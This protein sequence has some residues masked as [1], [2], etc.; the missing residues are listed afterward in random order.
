MS[1]LRLCLCVWRFASI[2]FGMFV[3][4]PAIAALIDD[5]FPKASS[6]CWGRVYDE[7]HLAKNAAQSVRAIY[8]STIDRGKNLERSAEDAA[9]VEDN[10]MPR[11]VV[12]QIY[13]ESR[14]GALIAGDTD[15]R[16]AA[17]GI[18]CFSP[19]SAT[20]G[21]E[22]TAFHLERVGERLQ[23]TAQAAAWPLRSFSELIARTD[24][25]STRPIPIGAEDRHFRLDRLPAAR[26][27][28]V[29]RR[30]VGAFTD[31]K[32]PS[33]LSRVKRAASSRVADRRKLCLQS[34]DE[35][36]AG[37]VTK[38]SLQLFLDTGKY[39]W[40]VEVDEFTF[41]VTQTLGE[42]RAV[43][44]LSCTARTYT[45]WCEWRIT[46]DDREQ[47]ANRLANRIPQREET[48]LLLR[49]ANGAIL[50]GFTCLA[51]RCE[52]NDARDIG[53]AWSTPGACEVAP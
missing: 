10:S 39:D 15:C 43:S 19:H 45:W 48:G 21:D 4:V 2:A 52:R 34:V 13:V 18:G 8:V 53:L 31:V 42:S 38:P 35:S 17:Q 27:A 41:R 23:L 25:R 51:G 32:Q 44:S 11:T 36:G 28:E 29:E 22:R 49:A 16:K 37:A 33:I 20:Q 24:E 26:C 6:A 46:D 12:P 30:Y 40:P 50:R 14:S 9:A 1:R 7:A 47:K 3:S 5:V